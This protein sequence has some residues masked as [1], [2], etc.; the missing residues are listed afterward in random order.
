MSEPFVHR[1]YMD[2]ESD[3]SS[4][5]LSVRQI[6]H[7]MIDADIFARCST[8]AE[9]NC[10]HHLLERNSYCLPVY[11]ASHAGSGIPYGPREGLWPANM[12]IQ[13]QR[14]ASASAAQFNSPQLPP[15]SLSEGGIPFHASSSSSPHSH[16]TANSGTDP[17]ISHHIPHVTMSTMASHAHYGGGLLDARE[18]HHEP[19]PAFA[20]ISD[21]YMVEYSR[22]LPS[23]SPSVATPIIPATFSDG[24]LSY[25]NPIFPSDPV[26]QCS[27]PHPANPLE[28]LFP[29]NSAPSFT[30]PRSLDYSSL[31]LPFSMTG[32][33]PII[34][35]C[36]TP[37]DQ[38]RHQSDNTTS[39]Q[40]EQSYALTVPLETVEFPLLPVGS[41]NEMPFFRCEWGDCGIWITSDK[42]AVKDHLARTHRVALRK[43]ADSVR[44]DWAG[45]SSSIQRT[46]LV[47]HF[48]THLGLKWLCSVCGGAYTRQDSV[49]CHARREP[50]CQ[51]AQAISFPSAMSYR[52]RI[53]RN[54]TVTLT[55]VLQ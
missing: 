4:S 3:R 41:I 12:L 43:T 6:H 44:C 33:I 15:P 51:Q 31:S 42:E 52:A 55:K 46:G 8:G 2:N 39:F 45:C 38:V 40:V 1:V 36:E 29:S 32:H 24:V 25:I 16:H 11:R 14:P 34:S 17:L 54:N 23:P 37:T 35:R 10:S 30:P 20:F 13:D 47:R 5:S 22:D 50:R 49:G 28:H 21:N 53:N 7:T 18:P 27:S 48:N 19:S 9:S 26:L